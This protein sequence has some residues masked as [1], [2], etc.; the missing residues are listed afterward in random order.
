MD[1]EE[2]ENGKVIVRR[3]NIFCKYCKEAKPAKIRICYYFSV[4]QKSY[5][6]LCE[7]CTIELRN[8]INKILN[9]VD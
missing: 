4:S 1:I 7:E 9:K 2:I 6:N 5:L 3:I 8:K